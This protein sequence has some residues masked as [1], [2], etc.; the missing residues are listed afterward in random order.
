MRTWVEKTWKPDY[1]AHARPRTYTSDVSL[2]DRWVIPTIGN[3]RLSDLTVQDLRALER[4][5]VVEGYA[6]PAPVMAAPLPRKGGSDRD[7]I[8]PVDC[9]RL[10]DAAAVRDQWTDPVVPEGVS[11]RAA[12]EIRRQHHRGAEVHRSRWLAAIL[13]GM[14]QGEGLGLTWDRVDLDRGLVRVD[15]QMVE[16]G[17]ND[18]PRASGLGYERVSGGYWWGPPKSEAGERDI[19]LIPVMVDALSEWRQVCPTLPPPRAGVASPVGCAVLQERRPGRLPRAAGRRRGPQGREG[20]AG[21]PLGLL[22]GARGASL[23]RDAADG[24]GR[25]R[26]GDRLDHGALV[27]RVDPPLPAR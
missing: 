10:L 5:A 7:A 8:A 14:R 24:A 19:L 1:R 22:R 21:Q 23:H 26:P 13:Q 11:G 15:R 9:G 16:L 4:A 20:H 18:D 6:V 25:A 27:D 3:R 12:R 2:I 17:R